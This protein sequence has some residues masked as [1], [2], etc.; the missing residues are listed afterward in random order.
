MPL[1][2]VYH[3][4]SIWWSCL[5]HMWILGPLVLSHGVCGM[6]IIADLCIPCHILI[7]WM[8]M[9]VMLW[10][11]VVYIS[12]GTVSWCPLHFCHTCS[13][14][15]IQPLLVLLDRLSGFAI[16]M[17]GFIILWH[18]GSIWWS[19]LRYM[20]IFCPLA[21]SHGICGM[22]T[23]AD[24][25]IPCQILIV[26]WIIMAVVLWT[27]V[28]YISYGTVSLCPL[29]F[30]HTCSFSSIQSQLVLLDRLSGFAIFTCGYIILWHRPMVYVASPSSLSILH[31][32]PSS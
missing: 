22:S 3:A 15:S 10:T 7:L 6:F 4:R 2:H 14:N 16:F 31:H 26:L 1:Y 27:R 25:C 11:R 8:T 13:F 30:C 17:C 19:C 9:A 20:W 12:Y 23:I 29:H 5:R 21:P 32:H 24:L 18:V 28:V